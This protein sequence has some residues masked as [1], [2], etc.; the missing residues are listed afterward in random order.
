MSL[1]VLASRPAREAAHPRVARAGRAAR[2]RAM[3]LSARILGRAAPAHRDRA[4]A[5]R[6]TRARSSA[7]SPPARSTSRCRRRSS[8]SS[9][10]CSARWGSR[11]C[12]SP[13]TSR[14]SS[15]SPHEVAVMYLGRIV[16]RGHG[17]GGARQ[18]AKHPYTRALLAAVPKLD[19]ER[20]TVKV[21]GELP[22]PVSPPSGCHFHPRCPHAIG[23][24][25]YGISRGGAAQRDARGALR[26][27]PKRIELG[28]PKT[29]FRAFHRGAGVRVC[30]VSL[31][32]EDRRAT[33]AGGLGW[34][35]VASLLS[36][37]SR[38]AWSSLRRSWPAVSSCPLPQC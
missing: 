3:A 24:L 9:S 23:D 6:W 4:R 13:T 15:T 11:T 18:P 10:A 22:S 30:S 21:E 20:Y 5:C 28:T 33:C 26:A 37:C 12:S 1:G 2:G 36:P 19:G 32:R 17:R 7:T 14:W 34:A 27:L 16:E 8:I 31:R 35:A 38:R 29:R 25:P